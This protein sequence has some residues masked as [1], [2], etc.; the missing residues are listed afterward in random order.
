MPWNAALVAASLD[1]MLSDIF[2]I[3]VGS[4]ERSI[5]AREVAC[6]G[7][8]DCARA[9]AAVCVRVWPQ[10]VVGSFCE[11]GLARGDCEPA[12]RLTGVSPCP[13]TRGSTVSCMANAT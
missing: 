9:P 1:V 8:R 12:A 3:S 4:L 13:S 2:A 5:P 7:M 6:D 10:G 11:M